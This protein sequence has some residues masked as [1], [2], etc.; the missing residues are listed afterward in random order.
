MINNSQ[1]V[2]EDRIKILQ[3]VENGRISASEG[4][5]L[6]GAL[7]QEKQAP[8]GPA[9]QNS[10]SP[11]WFRVRVTDLVNGKNKVTVN[12]PF[13]LMD[14]GLKVGAQFSPEV[15][16]INLYE[17]RDLLH[18]NIDGKLLEVIDEEDGERVEI[19]VD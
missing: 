4:A 14:W 9:P 3:M 13:S 6:L 15:K 7:S 19:Y 17:L 16:N 12:I 10:E 8:P 1:M 2:P 5:T 18:Q 11:S